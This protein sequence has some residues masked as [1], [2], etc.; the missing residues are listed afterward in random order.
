MSKMRSK[1]FDC[2]R[3]MREARE[4]LSAE[5]GDKSYDELVRWLRTHRYSDPVLQQLAE[6]AAQ[7]AAAADSGR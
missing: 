2:V 3:L 6:R 5:I 7:Q 4:K 1:S